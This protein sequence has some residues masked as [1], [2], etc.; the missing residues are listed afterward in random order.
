MKQSKKIDYTKLVCIGSSTKHHYNFTIFLDLKTFAERLYNGSLSL[1]A[2]KL[3]QRNME[4]M[5]IRL[6]YYKPNKHEIRAQ[7]DSV[8]LNAKEFY[9][10]RKMILI[11]FENSV[12]PLAKQYPSEDIGDWKE[13]VMD[14][15]HIIPEETDKLLP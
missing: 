9:K 3:K 10:G 13:D 6:E 12:F 14:S 11:A 1:Q 2:A 4:D 7:T 8:L 5:I 15:T